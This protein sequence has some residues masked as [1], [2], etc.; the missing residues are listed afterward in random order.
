MMARQPPLISLRF[1]ALRVPFSRSASGRRD[2]AK[3][4][5]RTTGDYNLHPR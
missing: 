5:S 3:R 2:P 1:I 4:P